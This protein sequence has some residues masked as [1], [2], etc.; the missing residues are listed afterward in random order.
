MLSA[1]LSIT[2]IISTS[3]PRS[4][5]GNRYHFELLAVSHCK[6]II[7]TFLI[8][9]DIKGQTI[10]SYLCYTTFKSSPAGFVLLKFE[11]YHCINNM[12]YIVLVVHCTWRHVNKKQVFFLSCWTCVSHQHLNSDTEG[13]TSLS[14][15]MVVLLLHNIHNS[16]GMFYLSYIA[17]TVTNELWFYLWRKNIT[18]LL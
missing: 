5:K 16:S 7:Q 14:Y 17:T 18:Q 6:S 15:I 4:K 11:Q 9:S 10:S 8:K 13:F 1:Q 2:L 3:L 12:I